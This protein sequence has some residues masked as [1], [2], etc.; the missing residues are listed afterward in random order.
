MR[1]RS[2][3]GS[4]DRAAR[5]RHQF[6]RAGSPSIMP[7]VMPNDGKVNLISTMPHV[8][9]PAAHWPHAT[10]L[11]ATPKM[12][13]NTWPQVMVQP[14]SK[15]THNATAEAVGR[16]CRARSNRCRAPGTAR[17]CAT[18]SPACP[19]PDHAPR[20]VRSTRRYSESGPH[21]AAR[22]Y[23]VTVLHRVCG[24]GARRT[25]DERRHHSRHPCRA[26]L[27]LLL[28]ADADQARSHDRRAGM[29]RTS[30]RTSGDREG[31]RTN[32]VTIFPP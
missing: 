30:A 22:G 18:R 10:T 28:K 20:V 32:L 19:R 26:G 12:R 17:G 11:P 21:A 6:R 25:G 3:R 9:E 8:V 31:R 1:A 27:P 5:P 13:T 29:R 15:L 2:P 14:S 4:G 16:N 7:P 23:A 24:C